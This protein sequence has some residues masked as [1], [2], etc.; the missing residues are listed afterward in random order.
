MQIKEKYIE[1]KQKIKEKMPVLEKIWKLKFV[2]EFL[3][4]IIF[5]KEVFNIVIFKAYNNIWNLEYLIKGTLSGL[6]LLGITIKLIKDNRKKLES[7]FLAIA[8]PL[9]IGYMVFMLVFSVPDEHTHLYRA[10][11]IARGEAFISLEQNEEKIPLAYVRIVNIK[12][13]KELLEAKESDIKIEND[14]EFDLFNSFITYFPGIYIGPVVGE[15]IGN[16]LNFNLVDVLYLMRMMNVI[17]Y[18]V[19]GYFTIKWIPFGKL[20]MLTYLCIPMVIHQ[21][22][23]ISADCFINSMGLLFIAYNMKLLFLKEKEAYS[24]K[25][26]VLYFVLALMATLNKSVYLP[27]AFLSVLLIFNKNTNKKDKIF[28]GATLGIMIIISAGW[29]LFGAQYKD[30]REYI[31]ESNVSSSAQ[32]KFIKENPVTFLEVLRNTVKDRMISYIYEAFGSRLGALN[33]SINNIWQTIYIFMLIFAVF[34]EKSEVRL[35]NWQKA[36]MMLLVFGMIFLIF[37][38]LYL[39]WTPPGNL[40]IEGIQGRYF[41]P[42]LIIPLLCIIPKNKW[43]E[44]KNTVPIYAILII[45]I[46]LISLKNII[47]F[48]IKK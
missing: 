39:T 29:Y 45:F 28:M 34:L 13:Y 22:A 12:Q 38:A 37:I 32:L 10:H 42:F 8:I 1:T 21:A 17:I 16:A 9:S 14:K 46:N 6:L 36:F 41:L 33:I 40:I 18:L 11:N 3:L 26:K 7:L 23:S 19:A 48:F 2:I 27:L 4:A 47:A 5:A 30:T 15:L 35:K 20:M 24:K 25:Q 31:I 43:L 44:F